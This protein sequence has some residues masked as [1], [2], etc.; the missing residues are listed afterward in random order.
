MNIRLA[1][2]LDKKYPDPGTYQLPHP[3]SDEA[4]REVR[5]ILRE[6]EREHGVS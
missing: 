2:K 4:D 5:G 1:E 6:Y 3:N